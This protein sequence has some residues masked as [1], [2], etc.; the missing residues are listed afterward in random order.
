[1]IDPNLDLPQYRSHK[2]VHAMPMTRGDYNSYR[3]WQMPEDEDPADPGYLVVYSRDTADHYESWS[4]KHVFDDGYT[5]VPEEESGTS[6]HP[7]FTDEHR[8]QWRMGLVVRHAAESL[9]S[10]ETAA[11]EFKKA[12]AVLTK[13]D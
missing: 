10:L 1:M 13:S 2:R 8:L 9:V 7:E 5:E 12:E 4:P 6:K 11:G 3:G